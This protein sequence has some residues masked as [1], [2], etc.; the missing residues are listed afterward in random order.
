MQTLTAANF[1]P[2]FYQGS[3]IRLNGRWMI[4]D[5]VDSSTTISIRRPML[6]HY[7]AWAVLGLWHSIFSR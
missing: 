4:V 1:G 5:S 3:V 2:L 6:G 7:I